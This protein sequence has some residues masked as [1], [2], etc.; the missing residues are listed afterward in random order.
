MITYNWLLSSESQNQHCFC[1]ELLSDKLQQSCL[2][3][4]GSGLGNYCGN[5]E[6]QHNQIVQD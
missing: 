1:V 2:S 4:R 5:N 6:S 3:Q